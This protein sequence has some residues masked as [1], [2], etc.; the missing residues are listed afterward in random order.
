MSPIYDLQRK[1]RELGRIRTG[2]Q[3]DDGQGRIRASSLDTFRL[4]SPIRRYIDAAAEA[5]GGRVEPWEQQWQVITTAPAID[6]VIPPGEPVSQWYELWKAGGCQRRCD[7]RVE[8]LSGQ[9]C[10]C[11][12]GEA[13]V[14]LAKDG[15]ACKITTR[16]SVILPAIPDLGVWRLES[17]GYYA[18]VEL[19]GAA[20]VLSAATA[21][22]VLVRARLRLDERVKKVPGQPPNRYRVPVLEIVGG[23]EDLMSIVES[24]DVV[25][26]P[27]LGP[28]RQ[29]VP[30]LPSTTLP[31]VSDLRAPDAPGL[32]TDELYEALRALRVDP[33]DA[34]LLA[35]DLYGA[36]S[37]L[38][39]AQRYDL[40]ERLTR[41]QASAR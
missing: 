3:V 40:V 5:Y 29:G 24:G 28:G 16:V 11:P 37:V 2:I 17:H 22:G 31:D 41:R 39:A 13:R 38:T 33:G 27:A 9:P 1:M 23:F 34:R 30:Q 32:T 10:L 21:Q 15:R 14:A 4:T 8:Q 25:A 18:G 19:A 12:K 7:G 26:R 35:N 36:D 20:E 6:I